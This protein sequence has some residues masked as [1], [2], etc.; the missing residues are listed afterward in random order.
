MQSGAAVVADLYY[1]PADTGTFII[2]YELEN[3]L[4]MN[5]FQNVH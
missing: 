4:R 1:S 5:I 2:P 3:I